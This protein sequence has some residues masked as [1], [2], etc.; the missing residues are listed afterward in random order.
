MVIAL[1]MSE[2]N[3]MV[4]KTANGKI[5]VEQSKNNTEKALILIHEL[6]HE[7]LHWNLETRPKLTREQKELE[8]EATAYVVANALQIPVTNSDRYLALYH[9]SYDLE[10]SLESIHETSQKILTEILNREGSK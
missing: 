2:V 8:A 6:A 10:E 3:K 1:L 5:K 4:F 9:K 7:L